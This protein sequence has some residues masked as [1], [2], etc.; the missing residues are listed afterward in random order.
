MGW[1]GNRGVIGMLDTFGRVGAAAVIGVGLVI[2]GTDS[3]VAPP[4][5]A[6]Q[7]QLTATVLAMG[8]LG[9]ETIEPELM[10]R[11]LAGRFANEDNLVGLPWPGE[12]APFNGT[13]TLN[14]SVAVG[15]E[16]LDTAIRDTPGEK[17]VVAASGSTLAVNEV[18]RRLAN[19]PNGP[20]AERNLVRGARRC[21]PRRVQAVAGAD[22]AGI[23][24]HR[25]RGSGDQVRRHGRRR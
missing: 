19:D 9:Y 20:S 13:L 16:T 5:E 11:V 8:G 18:M 24:L 25:P 12:L 14:E 2:S 21:R 23:R 22:P 4:P 15:L 17:I 7:F 3:S 10:R 1:Q 6:A